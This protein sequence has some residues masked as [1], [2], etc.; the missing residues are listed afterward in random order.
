MRCSHFYTIL[1]V[2]YRGGPTSK[3]DAGEFSLKREIFS[4]FPIL[5]YLLIRGFAGFY[6]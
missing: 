2:F 5:S 3:K 1:R 6:V 4:I